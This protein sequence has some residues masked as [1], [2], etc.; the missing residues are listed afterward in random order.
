MRALIGCE[1][2]GVVREAFRRR[3][4]DAWSCDLQDADD[5]SEFH[6]KGDVREA[7][8]RPG[9]D[10]FIVHP[11][12]TYLC[13]S[14]WHWTTRGRIEADGRPRMEHYHEA[15]AFAVS[16]MEFDIARIA[17]ENP[18][19]RLSSAYRKPDQIIQPYHFGE[20]ASKAT[21]LWLKGLRPL[22]ATGYF[23]P[24]LVCPCGTVYLDPDGLLKGC[25]GCGG[26]TSLARPRWSNQTD[27]GY[28]KL[29]PS[30]T[31]WKERS[32]TYPGIAD[33]MADQWSP[34]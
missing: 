8:A 13:G 3:G 19:G 10:L 34:A 11:T 25:P 28:N 30:P 21:C 26:E 29:A 2:S 23:P 16:L 32:R 15:V 7:A 6:I 20:D 27:G 31:R 14:G 22:R 1:S 4:W 5:G 9:W 18:V 24:R 17:M 12:C 33:A